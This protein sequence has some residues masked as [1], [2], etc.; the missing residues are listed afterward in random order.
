M[1]NKVDVLLVHHD[2]SDIEQIKKLFS[3]SGLSVMEA[4]T[5][6]EALEKVEHNEFSVL[7]TDVM[8]PDSSGIEL[9]K[10]LFETLPIVI[11]NDCPNFPI[12]GKIEDVCDCYVEKKEVPKRLVKATLKAI[13]RHELDLDLSHMSNEAA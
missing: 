2:P 6:K 12:E 3:N 11:V 4:S 8:M 9:S 1:I 10:A 7:V 13:E 5:C